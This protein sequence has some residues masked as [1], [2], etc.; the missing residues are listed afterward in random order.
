M[1]VAFIHAAFP[2]IVA[3]QFKRFFSDDTIDHG[4]V[5][6]NG[7]QFVIQ[8]RTIEYLVSLYLFTHGELRDPFIHSVFFGLNIAQRRPNLYI[9]L[10]IIA[11]IILEN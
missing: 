11:R 10:T 7:N 2:L 4:Y 1:T 9:D 6:R 3:D 5:K 8:F